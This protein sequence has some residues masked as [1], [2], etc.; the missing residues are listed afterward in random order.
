MER[1]YKDYFKAIL[2][3][4]A[5]WSIHD[6]SIDEKQSVVNIGIVEA[7]EKSKMPFMSIK[8]V[9]KDQG[10]VSKG[11]WQH[12]N[13]GHYKCFISASFSADEHM[14]TSGIARTS[15]SSASFLGALG[16]NY[17]H[18]LRQKVALS[19]AQGIE[20]NDIAAIHGVEL[21][22]V[23]SILKDVQESSDVVKQTCYLPTE[24]DSVWQ[25]IILDKKLL[26][27]QIL[28]LKLLLSKLKLAAITS[29]D[30]ATLRESILE[31]RGFFISQSANLANEIAQISGLSM[32]KQAVESRQRSSNKLMLP[33]LRSAIWVGLLTNT[34]SLNSNN[35][36][37]NL[38]L[39]RLRSTYQ[40]GET[41]AAKVQAVTSL[42]EFFRKNAR[43]LRSEL[44][45]IN[46]LMGATPKQKYTLPDSS[47]EIWRRILKDD[48]FI[49]SSHM[50]YKLLLSKL[51]SSMLMNPDP[52]IELGAAKRVRQFI[53]QNQRSMQQELKQVIRSSGA[54]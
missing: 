44:I 36:S 40:T 48:S 42:R 13:L 28:P 41:S 11:R 30:Q 22:L 9:A 24:S 19:S 1:T 50:A 23:E 49:P 15:L 54:A 33:A 31:L 20:K 21:S 39:V 34:L 18:L 5:P 47:H 17:T 27:T 43:A 46:R 29:A 32:K 12:T 37:L 53:A 38:L 3:I 35:M 16:K 51:R 26:K 7:V 52:Q 2:G 14:S 45:Q 6:I 10:P 4:S 8:K 25:D